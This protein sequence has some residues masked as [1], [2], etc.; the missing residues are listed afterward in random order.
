MG[1]SPRNMR[2]THGNARD[3]AGAEPEK[4]RKKIWKN[5]DLTKNNGIWS[6]KQ[7]GIFLGI[8]PD[9]KWGINYAI[10]MANDDSGWQCLMSEH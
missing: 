5:G 3:E 4:L 1:I 6:K 7:K 2:E 10:I 9:I 8:Q